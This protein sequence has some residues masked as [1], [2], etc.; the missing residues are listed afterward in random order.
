MRFFTLLFFALLCTGARAQVGVN[1]PSPE[2]ALDVNGKVKITD[3]AATPSPGTLRYDAR[4][5]AFQGFTSTGWKSFGNVEAGVLPANAEPF[6]GNVGGVERGN[7]GN[8]VF[9]DWA[10]IQNFSV[11]PEGK[12]LI[13]TALFPRPNALAI[14]QHFEFT[15]GPAGEFAPYPDGPTSLLFLMNTMDNRPILSEATPLFVVRGGQVLKFTH[16]LTSE[17]RFAQAS[18]RG[19]LIDAPQ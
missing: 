5:D 10:N 6:Y 18:I 16:E 4:G 11:V 14:D 1:N 3:D 19:Y 15:I 8:F 12:W 17:F 7:N 2:Q 9:R 13:V